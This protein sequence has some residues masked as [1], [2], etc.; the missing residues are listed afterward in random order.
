MARFREKEKSDDERDDGKHHRILKAEEHISRL[1]IH[2]KH[3]RRQQA[4]D[5][6]GTDLIR[7]RHRRIAD[8]GR[9]QF[10]DPC[11]CRPLR[12]L[13]EQYQDQQKVDHL[14]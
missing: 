13:R 7:Q 3:R 11:R 2:R 14:Q 8:V 4:A 1:G 6:A 10:H 12:H 5:P 9:E